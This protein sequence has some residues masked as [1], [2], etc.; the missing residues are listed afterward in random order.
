MRPFQPLVARCR[1]VPLPLVSHMWGHTLWTLFWTGPTT[2]CSGQSMASRPERMAAQMF[3]NHGGSGAATRLATPSGS[4]AKYP[5]SW[6]NEKNASFTFQRSLTDP[7]RRAIHGLPLQ[8]VP[9]GAGG[10]H[11]LWTGGDSPVDKWDGL[12]ITVSRGSFVLNFRV[13]ASGETRDNL[14]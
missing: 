6:R 1:S 14:L 4:R 9:G 12:W 7:H 13:E 10:P 11:G 8:V 3:R 2:Y 5:G